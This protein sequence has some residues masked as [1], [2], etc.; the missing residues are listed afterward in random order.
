MK[1]FLIGKYPSESDGL[2]AFPPGVFQLVQLPLN[3]PDR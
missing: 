3:I 1:I 2:E